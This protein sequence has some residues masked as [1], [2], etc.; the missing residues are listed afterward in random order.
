MRHSLSA[1]I[2]SLL[3]V[4]VL[5]FGGVM[6]YT[7]YRMHQVRR[8]LEL[9]NTRY[10]RLTLILGELQS[11][12]VNLLNTVAERAAGRGT[13][14]F[15]RRQVRLARQYRL[16]DLR[17]AHK[18]I[19]RAETLTLPPLDQQLSA[20]SRARLQRLST[21]YRRNEERFDRLFGN[22]ELE[23][24]ERQRV[25]ESLLRDERRQLSIIRRLS[26]DLR[27]R[28]KS[29]AVQVEAD[30]RAGILVGGMLVALA[31]LFSVLVAFRAHRLLL[32]LKVLVE[33]TKRIGSG[34]YSGRVAVA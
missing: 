4:V 7:I 15:L 27:A 33:G 23:A 2:F 5:A 1:R 14:K 28:V 16:Y 31:L 22:E 19:G 29:A 21:A 10:L 30:Q 3:L 25:G 9:I 20:R 32:P 13:S 34:D 8:H 12:E 17:K 24:K 6:G 26:N 11:I 18:L